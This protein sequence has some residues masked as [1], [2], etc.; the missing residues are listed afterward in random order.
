MESAAG[1]TRKVGAGETAIVVLAM[2]CKAGSATNFSDGGAVVVLT[3]AATAE[4]SSWSK[5]NSVAGSVAGRF[6]SLDISGVPFAMLP[7]TGL[8]VSVLGVMGAKSMVF[9]LLV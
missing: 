8:S 5:D 2:G 9:F 7:M 1:L 3:G 6:S 4:V